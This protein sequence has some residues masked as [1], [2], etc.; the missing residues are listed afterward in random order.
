MVPYAIILGEKYTYFLYH[1]Y[2]LI[3]N[4]KIE[5]G[6]L[7]NATNSLDPFYYHI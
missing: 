6:T 3:E 1:R 5:E 4:G 7:L 2:K